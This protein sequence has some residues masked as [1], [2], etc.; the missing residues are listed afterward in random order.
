MKNN[1]F[2]LMCVLLATLLPEKLAAKSVDLPIKARFLN[3][4][5]SEKGKPM[6]MVLSIGG[7]ELTHFKIRIANTTT[8]DYWMFYDLAAHKGKKLHIAYADDTSLEHIYIGDRIADEDQIYREAFR[9]QMHFSTR[10]GWI[11]DPNGLVYHD[12]EYHLFY[13]YNPYGVDWGNLNWG[14]AVSTDLVH[15][16]ELPLALA[17]DEYGEIYSGSAIIDQGN[18]SGLGK[19]K[20]PPMLAYYTVQ[21]RDG[22]TQCLAYSNDH[23]RTLTKY[24]GNPLLDTRMNRG[25]WHNRDPKVFWYAPGEHWVMMLHEKDGI[26]IYHSTDLLRWEYSSHVAGIWEC[27][28]LYELPIDG[29]KNNSRWVLQGAG[30]T[31][32]IGRFDGKTFTP[33]SEK[34]CYASGRFYA[35]QTFSGIPDTDGRRIQIGWANIRSKGMPFTGLMLF[36]TELSLHSSPNGPIRLYS[37]P[38]KEVEQ[39][40]TPVCTH[41][42][43][44]TAEEANKL[45]S[46]SLPAVD[47]AKV[48]CRITLSHPTN[49][50]LLLGGQKILDYDMIFSR[51]NGMFYTPQDPTSL[52]IDIDLYI[53]RSSIE[54]FVDGGRYMFAIERK[55]ET[56]NSALSFWYNMEAIAITQLTIS[57]GSSIWK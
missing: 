38:V 52:S 27:P 53:D 2:L 24:A 26:S 16:Q 40:F 33:E 35:P 48:S 19:G 50:G 10:R 4:P 12:G 3:L 14:H 8:P 1:F 44:L 41:P 34:Q 57:E 13:Q 39:L 56:A 23:G 28:D 43:T 37:K 29:N 20:V 54:G 51:V 30:G 21:C 49:A 7:K 25:S 6:E 42:D 55:P 17:I 46:E 47:C 11:N 18:V 36:P 9:P 22:Q 15:W 5:I 45:L 31:Y 32:L